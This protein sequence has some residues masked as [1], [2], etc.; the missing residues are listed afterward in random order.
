MVWVLQN[1]INPD[2]LT[3]LELGDAAN[4]ILERDKKYGTTEFK[5][6]AVLNPQRNKVLAAP[7]PTTFG[8]LIE[9]RDILPK[10]MQIM[11]GSSPQGSSLMRIS[12]GAPKT[13]KCRL[14]RLPNK[15]LN[16]SLSK[17]TK[18]VE[19]VSFY[20]CILPPELISR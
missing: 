5:V 8:E 17:K 19:R 16:F 15:M 4:S 10:Q 13:N 1:Q 6:L 20:P 9:S 3:H 18:P 14:S 7:A 2:K 12:L 11:Q